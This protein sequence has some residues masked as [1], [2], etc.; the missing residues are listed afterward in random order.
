MDVCAYRQTPSAADYEA[1]TLKRRRGSSTDP[2]VLEKAAKREMQE[3]L[4]RSA[5]GAVAREEREA[6][7]AADERAL[8]E[9]EGREAAERE[10]RR[11]REARLKVEAQRHEL[12][13]NAKVLQARNDQLEMEL[14]KLRAERRIDE[15]DE[16]HAPHGDDPVSSQ[17][18]NEDHARMLQPELAVG[19]HGEE[20]G[21]ETEVYEPGVPFVA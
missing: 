9:R 2:K 18:S 20:D 4:H 3:R 10:A 19:A 15:D 21:Y 17:I 16:Q 5:V 8:R 13:V 14:A 1:V 7:R 12:E 11:E 6:C